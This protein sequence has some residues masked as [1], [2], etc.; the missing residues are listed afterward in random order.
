VL[1]T[2]GLP[3]CSGTVDG[4]VTTLTNLRTTDGIDTF[5]LGIP[6]GD[7]SLVAALNRMADAGGRARAGATHFYEIG[8]TLDLERALRGVVASAS[9]CAYVLPLAATISTRVTIAFDGVAVPRD[10]VNG[11]DFTSS[12]RNE[13]RF[14]GAACAQLTAGTVAGLTASFACR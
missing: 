3:T 13:V 10:P 11:W 1:A 7:V 8:G 14:A 12:A 2:D 5:V 9:G 6:G 4:V